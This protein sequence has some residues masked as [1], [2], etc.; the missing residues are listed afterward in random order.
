[1]IAAPPHHHVDDPPPLH[2]EGLKEGFG[3]GL[4]RVHTPRWSF[5]D[6]GRRALVDEDHLFGVFSFGFRATL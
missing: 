5:A 6:V 2:H 4:C 3:G 1:M